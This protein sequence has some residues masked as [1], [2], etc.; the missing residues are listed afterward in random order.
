MKTIKVIVQPVID[1]VWVRRRDDNG[2]VID[3]K[4]FDSEYFINQTTINEEMGEGDGFEED[5]TNSE[6]DDGD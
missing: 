4:M 1:R 3:D 6:F 5:W 2:L